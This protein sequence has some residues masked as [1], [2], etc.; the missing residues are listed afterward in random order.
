[1]GVEID[2]TL[3][4]VNFELKRLGWVVALPIGVEIPSGVL[5]RA[6]RQALSEPTA[7]ARAR[8]VM[9]VLKCEGLDKPVF[10]AAEFFAWL[11]SG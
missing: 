10:L 11:G 6:D 4:L 3:G 7:L 1:M 8:A 9:D 5:T 2:E